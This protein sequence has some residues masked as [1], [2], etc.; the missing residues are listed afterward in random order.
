MRFKDSRTNNGMKILITTGIYPPDLGGPA[1]YVKH[2]E[3]VWSRQGHE[4]RIATYRW[5]RSIPSP[6]RH[7]AY[8]LKVLKKSFGVE[9]ILVLDTWSAALPTMVVCAISGK[10]YVIRTGGDFLWESYVERTGEK[11]LFKD[12]YDMSIVRFNKK[13]KIIFNLTKLLLNR[14][15]ILIFSTEWQKNIFEKAYSLDSNKNVIIEN[16]YES[17]NEDKSILPTEPSNRNFIAGS[18]RVKFKNIDLLESAFQKA[19]SE[20]RDRGFG[21]IELDTRHYLHEEFLQTIKRSYA[22]I[23]VSLGDISPNI[24]MEALRF[25]VPCIVTRENGVMNRIKD[26]VLL[27]NPL[28]EED[29]KKNIVWL[30]DPAHREKLARK[31][32]TFTFTHTWEEIAREIENVWERIT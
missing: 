21:G 30:S 11:V 18:R 24:I 27:V 23:L 13:E 5:E 14:A 7:V 4:V 12:F 29:I 9:K 25:G 6:L 16:C 19:R 32:R 8:F 1:T 26:Y 20:V 22:V 15:K 10:Q 17:P 3:E 2:L 31:A 28:D